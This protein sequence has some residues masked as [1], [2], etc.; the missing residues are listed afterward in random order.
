MLPGR[1]IPRAL[2]KRLANEEWENGFPT[3][4]G[5]GCLARRPYDSPRGGRA[6]MFPV[7]SVEGGEMRPY[8]TLGERP[9]GRL[10][11]SGCVRQTSLVCTPGGGNKI[12]R[13]IRRD[14]GCGAEWGNGCCRKIVGVDSARAEGGL[15]VFGLT[16]GQP[17]VVQALP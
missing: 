11:P 6:F 1:G 3:Q 17:C 14:T 16:R 8:I 10:G 7:A 13:W 12:L 4:L 15:P 2:V 5:V 9:P